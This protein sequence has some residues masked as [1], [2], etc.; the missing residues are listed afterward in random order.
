[1]HKWARNIEAREKNRSCPNFHTTGASKHLSWINEKPT[2]HNTKTAVSLSQISECCLKTE[3]AQLQLTRKKRC[4]VSWPIR[5]NQSDIHKGHPWHTWSCDTLMNVP[6]STQKIIKC[7][8]L[9]TIKFLTPKWS[10]VCEEKRN[11]ATCRQGLL[12]QIP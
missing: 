11:I 5:K 2:H 9:I 6:K 10:Y 12:E 1:M 8:V 7:A 3:N 4:R